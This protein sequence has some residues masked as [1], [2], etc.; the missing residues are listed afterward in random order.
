MTRS[1]TTVGLLISAACLFAA[2]TPA[3]ARQPAPH[4]V[5]HHAAAMHHAP[6]AAT[7]GSA[8]QVCQPFMSCDA[9]WGNSHNASPNL[10]P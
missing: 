9:H 6:A 10:M 4:A 1:L 7:T 3:Q 8:D 2:G 5:H